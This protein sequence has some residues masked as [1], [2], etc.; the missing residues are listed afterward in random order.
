MAAAGE[1]GSIVSILCDSGERYASTLYN[2]DWLSERDIAIATPMAQLESFL[3]G[4]GTLPHQ[5]LA[6]HA[7][8]PAGAMKSYRAVSRAAPEPRNGAAGA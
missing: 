7:A 3:H 5:M 4:R 1:T 2:D 6:C 8:L